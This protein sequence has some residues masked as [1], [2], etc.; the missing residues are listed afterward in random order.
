MVAEM[1]YYLQENIHTREVDWLAWEDPF[2]LAR[3]PA[4][5]KHERE[6]SNQETQKRLAYVLPMVEMLV[7]FS[8]NG[9]D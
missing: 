3:D 5:L 2:I 4:E 9:N 6:N 8:R 7:K 1:I